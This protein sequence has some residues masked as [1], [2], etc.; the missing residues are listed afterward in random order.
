LCSWGDNNEPFAARNFELGGENLRLLLPLQH[1]L[2]EF[3]DD[4]QLLYLRQKAIRGLEFCF[5]GGRT[6]SAA[7]RSAS[8]CS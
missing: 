6:S 2:L 1:L 4:S 5:S 7:R 3:F 8:L